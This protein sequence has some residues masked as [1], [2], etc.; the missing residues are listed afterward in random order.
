MAEEDDVPTP[1]P[2]AWSSEVAAIIRSASPLPPREKVMRR[3][4]RGMGRGEVREERSELVRLNHLASPA[5][6]RGPRCLADSAIPSFT[7]LSTAT[8]AKTTGIREL[9]VSISG[10]WSL[11]FKTDEAYEFKV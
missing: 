10:I 11:G 1:L 9:G 3:E 4:R 7:R 2:P 6:E 8:R 5:T